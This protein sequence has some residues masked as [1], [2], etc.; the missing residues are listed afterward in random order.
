MKDYL[1]VANQTLLGDHLLDEVRRRV[2]LD[3]DSRFHVVVPASHPRRTWTWTEAHD[4]SAA[5]NR[6]TL[7]LIGLRTKGAV[8]EGTIGDASPIESIADHVRR[9]PVDE[10]IL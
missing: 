5:R 8:A 1:V 7:A 9:H 3:P 4:R 10:I 6:L 2:A